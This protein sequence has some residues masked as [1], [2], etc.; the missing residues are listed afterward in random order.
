[1]VILGAVIQKVTGMSLEGFFKKAFFDPLGMTHTYVYNPN[2][3]RTYKKRSLTYDY[4]T[5]PIPDERFDGVVGD[6]NVYST[7]EDLLKWDQALYPGHLFSK[8]E[9]KEAFTP[10]SNEK[11]GIKN[12]GLRWHL[13]CYPDS[14]K[15]VY[16]N[17]WWHGNTS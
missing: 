17:G 4:R 10:Y 12:Y 11:R 3:G 8:E 13:L 15:V 1:Y 6:K 5:H 16:H 7:T 9:L 14:L 2:T